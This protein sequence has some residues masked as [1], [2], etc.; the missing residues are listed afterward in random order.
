M[1]QLPFLA[2]RDAPVCYVRASHVDPKTGE[3]DAK[4]EMSAQI[5]PGSTLL[6]GRY[7][8]SA[9][10]PAALRGGG[11]KALRLL[12]PSDTHVSSL[13]LAIW[14]DGQHFKVS[15]LGMNPIVCQTWGLPGTTLTQGGDERLTQLATLWLPR[16]NGTQGAVSRRWRIAIAHS[17]PVDGMGGYERRTGTGMLPPP[18]P[19]SEEQRSTIVER[20]GAFLDFPSRTMTPRARRIQ[21]VPDAPKSRKERLETVRGNIEKQ[22]GLSG[23]GL[24]IDLLAQLMRPGGLAPHEIAADPR[25]DLE[26]LRELDLLP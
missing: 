23:L 11:H 6:I 18:P 9:L 19:I 13:Q 12:V 7:P 16:S 22:L 4:D 1:N 15:S 3:R 26:L 17:G 25:V 8:D 24:D 2:P 21:T 10:A 14:H 20:F 5:G